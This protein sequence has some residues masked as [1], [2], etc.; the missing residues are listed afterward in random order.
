M[1]PRFRWVVLVVFASLSLTSVAFAANEPTTDAKKQTA[2][3]S[4]KT[5][6]AKAKSLKALAA[7]LPKAS[8][9]PHSSRS[10]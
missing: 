7:I 5:S 8:P 2:H 10:E 9:H 4:K 3:P 1:R 6:A